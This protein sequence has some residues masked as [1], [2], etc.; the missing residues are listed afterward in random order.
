MS[1]VKHILQEELDR[2]IELLS[3]YE[4]ELQNLP[5]GSLSKKIRDGKNYFY[6]AYREGKKVRFKYIG[7]ES[8][9]PFKQALPSYQRRMKYRRLYKEV[10]GD[11]DEIQRAL[12][13]TKR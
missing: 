10:K 13:A 3:K 5:K 9:D 8:S 11:I 7:K 1:I 12:N 2:L 4:E 6:E